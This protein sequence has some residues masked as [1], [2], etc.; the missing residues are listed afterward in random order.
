MNKPYIVTF[1]GVRHR[2]AAQF[3]V[4]AGSA[5]EAIEV[6]WESANSDFQVGHKKGAAQVKEFKRGALRIL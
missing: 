4:M 3:I 6:A 2:K 1:P 5:K